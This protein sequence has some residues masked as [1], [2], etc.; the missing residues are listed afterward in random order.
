[1]MKTVIK[2]VLAGSL[3]LLPMFGVFAKTPACVI[4]LLSA[5]PSAV[6]DGGSVTINIETTNCTNATIFGLDAS[7]PNAGLVVQT[8]SSISSGPIEGTRKFT[9]EAT[10]GDSNLVSKSFM[11]SPGSFSQSAQNNWFANVWSAFLALFG[12]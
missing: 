2:S 8:N 3:L 1:M 10:N 7:N 12:L 9:L 11:V 5:V 6:E 4:N